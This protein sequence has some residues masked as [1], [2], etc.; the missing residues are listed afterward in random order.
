LMTFPEGSY[1]IS[2]VVGSDGQPIIEG[3]IPSLEKKEAAWKKIKGCGADGRLCRVFASLDYF[4][5]YK[6]KLESTLRQAEFKNAMRERI[7]NFPPY[8]P[9]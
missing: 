2:N 9:N 1:L 3:R 6:D 4:L 5:A 8:T 7:T